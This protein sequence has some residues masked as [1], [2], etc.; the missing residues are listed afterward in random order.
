MEELGVSASQVDRSM[1]FDTS[2]GIGP[3]LVQLHDLSALNPSFSSSA[4][5]D[6]K[7]YSTFINYSNLLA[8]S[9]SRKH[10]KKLDNE[11][12]SNNNINS[13]KFHMNDQN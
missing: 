5:L 12:K 6:D 10:K 3:C 2:V 11:S 9:I 1:F 13:L 8:F 4:S 7:P